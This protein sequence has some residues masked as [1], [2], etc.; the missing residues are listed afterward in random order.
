MSRLSWRWLGGKLLAAF[1]TLIFVLVFNFFLFRVMGDPTTQLARVPGS[2]PAETAKLRHDLG[3]DR[4]LPGQFVEYA[5]DTAT[6]DLGTGYRSREP[7]LD[8][9]ADA[10][11]WTLL[12]VGAGTLFATLIGAWMG[13]RAAVNRGK[14]TDD[15]LMGFSLFT[16]AA[17]EYWI[18]IILILVFA[19]GFPWFPAGLQQTP[20]VTFDSD[21]EKVH[22]IAAHLVLPATAMT[23][24]LLGQYFLIMRS[25]MVDVMTE[26]FIAVKR[27]TGLSRERVINRHAVPN[28]LLPLVTISAIQFGAVFG[29][30]ITIETIFSWPGLGELSYQAIQ[31]KDFPV[32]QGTFL[33]FSVGVILANL[34]ADA[35]YFVLDP[36]VQAR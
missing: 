8:Q 27:A 30:A 34:I 15:S 1:V 19:V 18:G 23:L 26:D 5:K 12:L 2:T 36:R 28:A 31:D 11:P 9:M 7:V 10:L 14:R 6:F 20:G 25:S 4:S 22:D 32:L 33:L 3:L 29:G 21:F 17:P 16:Y 24:M 13:V 35:L